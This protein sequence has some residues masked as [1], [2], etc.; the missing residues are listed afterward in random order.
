MTPPP[1][2]YI[3]HES[4]IGDWEMAIRPP[5]AKLL[6]FVRS[7]EGYIDRTP[8]Q[9]R[10]LHVPQ[11]IVVLIITLGSVMRVIDP[12][13]PATE[14]A[15]LGTYVAGLFDSYVL[16][17]FTASS[18]GIQVNFTPLGAHLFLR[19]PMDSV[20]NRAVELDEILGPSSRRLEEQLT[21]LPDW[22][23]RFALLDAFILQRIAEAATPSRAVNLAW[24]RLRATNGQVQITSL[25]EEVECS[26]KHLIAGFREQIG[27]P[28]RTMARILR[29]ERT[30]Q[31]L[32]ERPVERLADLALD[33]GYYDQ[34]HFNRDFREFA[35]MT[36]QDYI[37]RLLPEG[38]GVSGDG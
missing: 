28:P 36:P 7:Y 2:R 33:C 13:V 30:V 9:G 1:L 32:G 11:S 5:A 34:S 18:K 25:A 23:S 21:D 29:F 8:G 24:K 12:R 35:G 37:A 3:R 19:V 27:L 17:Q 26:H 14:T 31:V 4:E 10:R 20:A 38:G 15:L 6:P 22:E 16:T